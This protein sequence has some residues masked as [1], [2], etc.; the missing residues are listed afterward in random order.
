MV[1]QVVASCSQIFSEPEGAAF[2]ADLLVALPDQIKYIIVERYFNFSSPKLSR[3]H[4]H[5]YSTLAK[6]GVSR[7]NRGN[8]KPH[9]VTARISGRTRLD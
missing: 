3:T 8:P 7:P 5:F 2:M 9:E 6:V 1:T 4:H